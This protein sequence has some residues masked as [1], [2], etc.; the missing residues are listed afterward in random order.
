[1]NSQK[2]HLLNDNLKKYSKFTIYDFEEI[3]DHIKSRKYEKVDELIDNLNKVFEYSKSNAISKNDE[4]LANIFYLLQLYLSIL[5]SISDLWKSLDTEKYGLSWGYLQDALI[6]IQL[7]KKFMCEPTELCVITLESYLKK[8]ECF[9]PYNIFMSPEYIYEGETCSICGK[10][11]YDPACSHIEG[12]LYGGKLAK[13]IHGN[14][15]VKSISLVKNPKNKKCV[16]TSSQNVDGS[17][18]VEVSFDN[19][20]TLV[21]TLGKPLV[22]FNRD[23]SE[24]I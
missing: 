18:K 8:L 11:P 17:D 24:N 16:I 1:M 21:N 9:Y 19:L 7:L 6:K 22:D 3:L 14:F 4:D 10:S 20:R 15:R 5:K 13:R 23:K 12:H 2:Y